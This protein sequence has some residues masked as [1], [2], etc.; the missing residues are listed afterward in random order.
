MLFLIYLQISLAGVTE[1]ESVTDARENEVRRKLRQR[2][3]IAR[4]RPEND[5]RFEGRN[6]HAGGRRF[7]S[8]DYSEDGS[9]D[10]GGFSRQEYARRNGGYK[11]S[12]ESRGYSDKDYESEEEEDDEDIKKEPLDDTDDEDDRRNSFTPVKFNPRVEKE[13]DSIQMKN[14]GK[15]QYLRQNDDTGSI[16]MGSNGR[17]L[18]RSMSSFSQPDNLSK[19]SSQSSGLNDPVRNAPTPPPP[20]PMNIP[21]KFGPTSQPR[22]QPRPVPAPRPKP[23]PSA[24]S[25]G[26]REDITENPDVKLNNLSQDEMSEKGR[27]RERLDNIG[28]MYDRKKSPSRENLNDFM[29]PEKSVLSRSREKIHGSQ[30]DLTGVGIGIDYLP[31]ADAD[32]YDYESG[33]ESPLH[34]SREHLIPKSKKTDEFQLGYPFSPRTENLSRPET[35]L[36]NSSREYLVPFR[37]RETPQNTDYPDQTGVDYLPRNQGTPRGQQNNTGRLPSANESM[38]G[39]PA[40]FRAPYYDKP[41]AQY[42]GSHGNMYPSN[43]PDAGVDYLPRYQTR[44]SP[45]P[46]YSP[47]PSYT[48]TQ[49]IPSPGLH[50]NQEYQPA[51]TSRKNMS[52]SRDNLSR[53]R[54]NLSRS[55][56]YLNRSRENLRNDL[57]ENSLDVVKPKPHKSIETEI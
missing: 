37:G 34:Q 6:G 21:A 10:E 47:A 26:S 54:E 4:G 36:V 55:R 50:Q 5:P 18:S 12:E 3:E 23:I 20:L 28:N 27:S 17:Q 33:R 51:V 9:D 49:G 41:H 19:P 43:E 53:S 42:P 25:F 38:A 48:S 57:R 15:I 45:A 39:N 56:E 13:L 7:R 44:H 11:H 31:R 8:R 46:P 24:R 52:S 35:D 32:K 1:D 29:A 40:N 30:G 14:D 22:T 2:A 16:D